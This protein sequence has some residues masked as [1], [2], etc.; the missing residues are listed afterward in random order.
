MT[1]SSMTGFA[2]SEG[3]V[4][5]I[6]WVWELKSVNGRSLDLR[7]RLPPGYDAMEAPLRAALG[8]RLRRGSISGEAVKQKF[9]CTGGSR[10]CGR[11]SNGTG[12]ARIRRVTFCIGIGRRD[13]A[14]EFTTT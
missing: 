12:T 7:L 5:G 14:G 9:L 10:I 4:A 1:V 6:S 11:P 8:G 2:R 13:G 3:E